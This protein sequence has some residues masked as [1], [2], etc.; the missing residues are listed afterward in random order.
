MVVVELSVEYKGTWAP[1][2][3]RMVG[4]GDILPGAISVVPSVCGTMMLELLV[5]QRCRIPN[6]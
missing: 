4:L 5:S 3:V 2:E 6:N 1:E